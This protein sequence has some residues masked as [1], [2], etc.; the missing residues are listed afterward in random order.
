MFLTPKQMGLNESEI[1]EIAER[2]WKEEEISKCPDCQVEPGENHDEMCD[3][4]R[5]TSCKGQ[6]LSCDCE[7]G[8]PDIWTGKWPGV[9]E[10]YERKLICYDKCKLPNGKEIGWTFDLNNLP[11]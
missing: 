1:A 6:R 5:C 2:L 11:R 3:V 7:D 8:E 10:C 9:K 4:A